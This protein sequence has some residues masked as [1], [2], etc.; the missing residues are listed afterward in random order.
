MPFRRT[1][2]V[3]CALPSSNSSCLLGA[4]PTSSARKRSRL[5][6]PALIELAKMRHCLLDNAPPDPHAAHQ[7]PVA[8]NL[9]VLPFA[10]CVA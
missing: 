1:G 4:V 2:T 8:M 7:T 10:N 5:N 3:R 6:A 9:P